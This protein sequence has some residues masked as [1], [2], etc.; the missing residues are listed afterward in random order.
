MIKMIDKALMYGFG[1]AS[2]A[3]YIYSLMEIF[4]HEYQKAIALGVASIISLMFLNL[5]EKE[6]KEETE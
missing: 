3:F 2:M 4:Q 1:T 6:T 5:C